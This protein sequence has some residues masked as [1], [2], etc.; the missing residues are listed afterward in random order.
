MLRI[1]PGSGEP[2]LI[3]ARRTGVAWRAG[4]VGRLYGFGRERGTIGVEVG[5][6]IGVEE[7]LSFGFGDGLALVEGSD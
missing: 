6:A 2:Y 5:Y 1:A 3:D 7:G 4:A